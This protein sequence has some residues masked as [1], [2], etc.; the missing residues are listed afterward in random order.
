MSDCCSTSNSANANKAQTRIAPNKH[1]C[2]TN[3]K[4]YTKVSEHTLFHHLKHP[5]LWNANTTQSYY[6]CDDP[7]CAVV[8]FGEDDSIIEKSQVRN[9]IGIKEQDN[10]NG[11]VCYCFG[12]TFAD[13]RKNNA[14]KNY[15]VDMTK[16]KKCAC[17]TRNPSG[18][19]C[20]KDFPKT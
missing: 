3:G 19:C 14:I 5:W 16:Q 11:L 9:T 7:T 13:A 17:D 1:I 8:Y 15:V 4:P 12:V 20:L 6:F 2:P 18:R 10:D